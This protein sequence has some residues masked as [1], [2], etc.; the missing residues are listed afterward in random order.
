V[1][2]LWDMRGVRLS[3]TTTEED[4]ERRVKL[5]EERVAE[6]ALQ[7]SNMGMYLAMEARAKKG[8]A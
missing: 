1:S 2:P 3:M 4:L 5:L 8:K 7:V 6:L